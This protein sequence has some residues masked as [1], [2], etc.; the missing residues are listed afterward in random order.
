MLF[1]KDSESSTPQNIYGYSSLTNHK[2]RT[3][4]AQ[5]CWRIMDYLISNVFL[6][7]PAHG[8]TSI[9]RHAKIYIHQHCTDTGCR[10]EKLTRVMPNR[11]AWCKSVKEFR[12]TSKLYNDDVMPDPSQFYQVVLLGRTKSHSTVYTNG[13]TINFAYKN[14]FPLSSR[15]ADSTDFPDSLSLSL[16]LSLSLSLSLSTLSV[17]ITD[18]SR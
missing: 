2:R 13:W 6:R 14:K 8:H 7:T 9:G 18:C 12:A 3:R 5:N 17:P 4:L 10:V 16:F 11:D 15:R 1:L